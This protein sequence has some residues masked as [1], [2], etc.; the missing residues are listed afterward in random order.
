MPSAAAPTISFSED[1]MT[2]LRHLRRAFLQ[3][4]GVPP[5]KYDD[6]TQR[7]EAAE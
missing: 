3:R 4:G 6:L 7:D 2:R 1:E 5:G